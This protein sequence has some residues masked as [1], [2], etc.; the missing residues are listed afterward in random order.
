MSEVSLAEWERFLRRYPD[1][2][3]LQTGNWGE[4]KSSFGW[5]A[6]RV[7]EAGG[8]AGAQVLFR[9]LALGLNVAYI[10]KGPVSSPDCGPDSPA[11]NQLWPA[12]DALCRRR[13]AIFL[14]VEAD[15]WQSD[16]RGVSASHAIPGGFR[17]SPHEIQ[18]RRTLLLD[19]RQDENTL[20]GRM[21]QKTRYNIRL[22]Q[23]KGVAVHPSDDLET[24]HRLML[25]TGQ[26]DVFGVHSLAYYQ[27]AYELFYPQ[28]EAELLMATFENKP[29]AALMVFAHGRRAWY[30]YGAS[31]DDHRDLMPTYLL[32]WEAIRW[33]KGRGCELYDLWGVP[34]VDE[35]Q[36]EEQFTRRTDGLWGVYRFKRGFGGRLCRAVS[37]WDRVYSPALYW[38]Y[39]RWVARR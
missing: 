7:L 12:V 20:L 4:L 26:R 22:A 14:K 37:A 11:W 9:R 28:G 31:A 19:I 8:E 27:R 23:K 21:K 3:I 36:L 13:R 18:P 10:P 17:P 2:H 1:A 33:A 15:L 29:L 38:L 25:V 24:F 16:I 35:E 34:D 32:Q 5:S 30:F 6:A 39:T